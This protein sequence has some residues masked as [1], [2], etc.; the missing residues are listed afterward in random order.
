MPDVLNRASMPEPI[1]VTPLEAVLLIKSIT[2]N[3]QSG[4]PESIRPVYGVFDA[5][6]FQNEISGAYKCSSYV[7]AP[8]FI[9]NCGIRNTA[10][11]AISTRRAGARG[12]Y[13]GHGLRVTRIHRPSF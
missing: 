6:V 12:E 5:N 9:V 13:V 2:E 11:C 10:G 8:I 1:D 3:P 7:V 4:N